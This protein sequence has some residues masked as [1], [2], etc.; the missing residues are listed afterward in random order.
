MG[1]SNSS[2]GTCQ[3]LAREAVGVF[4]SSE[5]LEAAVDDLGISGFDRATVSVPAT[6]E[7]IRDRVGHIY[8]TVGEVEDNP[9]V[10][11]AAFASQDSRIEGEAAAVGIPFYIGS[12]AGAG[13]AVAFG[14]GLV[15]AIGATIAGGAVGAG[16]GALVAAGMARRHSERV[17]EQLAQGGMVLW[18]SVRDDK[19][20]RRAV[21]ILKRNGAWDVH[22][23]EIE[24]EWTLKDRPLSEAQFDPFLCWP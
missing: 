3:Y 6:D 14:G 8:R 1:H 10:P 24:R 17:R 21:E 5:L 11:Q 19:A 20:E 9:S 7:T 15:I 4:S 18:V 16:L 23:H 12:C 2:D 22:V 13:A